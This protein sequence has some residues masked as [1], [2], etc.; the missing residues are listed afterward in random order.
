MHTQTHQPDAA[1]AH[2]PSRRYLCRHVH[3]NGNRCGSPALRG[4]HFC[5]YHDRTRLPNAPLAG[6]LGMFKM[7]PI[8]DRHAIQIALY[9]ILCRIAAGDVD[10]KRAS[11]LLYGLQIASSNLAHRDKAQLPEAP[12]EHV[13]THLRLGDLAPIQ[14][15]IETEPA[16]QL[17]AE[18]LTTAEERH[19][20]PVPSDGVIL[21]L[22]EVKGKDLSSSEATEPQSALPPLDPVSLSEACSAESKD[23]ERLDPPT[24]P[25]PFNHEPTPAT[26]TL[27]AEHSHAISAPLSLQAD[28]DFSSDASFNSTTMTRSSL[29]PTLSSVCGP[30]GG[31]HNAILSGFLCASRESITTAPVSSRRTQSLQLT[32]YRAAGHRCVCSGTVSPA[33]TRV[34]STRT[35]SFSSINP[36]CRGAARSA[37]SSSGQRHTSSAMRTSLLPEAALWKISPLCRFVIARLRGC[38]NF[39][40]PQEE[41]F[42]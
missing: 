6:R 27:A 5:Y 29:T 36:C 34:S 24:P 39:L 3:T 8:D 35:R 19:P 1:T 4:Q 38:G 41:D 33:A 42:S 12:V 20:Q 26:L 22:S 37:S 25:E 32:T 28:A 21:T 9:D 17:T 30:K 16:E 10:N 14:E 15:I 31:D 2:D 18:Q 23:L 11:I 13:T 40:A 7:Q